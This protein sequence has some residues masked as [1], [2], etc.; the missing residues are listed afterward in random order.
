MIAEFKKI[1]EEIPEDL[2]KT[3]GFQSDTDWTTEIKKR[4]FEFA[5]KNYKICATISPSVKADYGEWLYDLCWLEYGEDN[6]K[7]HYKYLKNIVLALESE[8]G[9]SSQVIGDFHKLLQA[10]AQYKVMIFQSKKPNDLFKYMIKNINDY[11]KKDEEK[12]LLACYNNIDKKF[13]FEEL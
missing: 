6:E 13:E 10:K 3:G 2:L 11:W 4:F 1:L 12:Y 8:W 5:P 9:N 7:Y